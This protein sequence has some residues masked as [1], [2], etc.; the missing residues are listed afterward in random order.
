Y[1]QALS[2]WEGTFSATFNDYIRTEL[3][4]KTDNKYAIW[5]RVRPWNRDQRVNVG[6]MLRQAMYENRFLEVMILEGY[7]DA[8]CDYFT[9]LYAFSHIDMNGELKD[10]IKF[11]FYESGHM[12]YAHLPSL[13]KMKND[14]AEF[15]RNA[16]R[17]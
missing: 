12:M 8:A 6:E 13:I 16:S 11:T 3:N 5:G 15:I 9:A 4:Y 14:M 2:D 7:Y 17:K 10:R 1:D